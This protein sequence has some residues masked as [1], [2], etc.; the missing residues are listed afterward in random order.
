MFLSTMQKPL[1]DCEERP[2]V[3]LPLERFG[4]RFLVKCHQL[5]LGL[6]TERS[7]APS[8][9]STLSQYTAS[10]AQFMTLELT[11]HLSY[12][13]PGFTLVASVQVCMSLCCYRLNPS[14]WSWLSLMLIR[15][16]RSPRTST[17]ISTLPSCV[18]WSLLPVDSRTVDHTHSAR[19]PP[20]L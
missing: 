13:E 20:E 15:W 4:K 1:G 5:R 6:T 19:R 17:L 7:G 10:Q 18:R 16:W 12:C 11:Q 14:F 8:H 9:V 3:S 2:T